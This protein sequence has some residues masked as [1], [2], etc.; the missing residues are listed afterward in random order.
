MVFDPNSEFDQINAWKTK[1]ETL[2][3]Q[4]ERIQEDARAILEMFGARKR[5][6]GSFS[7]D[8][9]HLAAALPIEKALELRA[10]IDKYHRISG[11]PGDKAR[12]RLPT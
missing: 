11:A 9:D 10:A 12:I 5:S 1:Y 6:D 2:K 7:I 4:T 3:G 8:F